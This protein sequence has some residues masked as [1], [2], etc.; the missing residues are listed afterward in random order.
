M[1]HFAF[2]APPLRG[3]YRP[4][5]NLA[6]ALI[7]RGHRATFVHHPDAAPLVE[8]EGAG[9]EPIGRAAPPVAGWTAPMAKIKGLIG[10]GG[11][12]DGMVRFTDMFCAEAPEAL[13][14]IGAD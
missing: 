4:L 11:V 13:R 2:I 8:A 14:R 9:F 12:M 10:L 3:H 5:S 7:A 6:S 1:A